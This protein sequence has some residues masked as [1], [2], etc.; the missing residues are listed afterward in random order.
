MPGRAPARARA[1][2]PE[3]GFVYCCFNNNYKITPAIFDVWMRILQRTGDS[4]LW[5]LE[6]NPAAARNLRREAERRGVAP[7]RL[8]FAPRVGPEE[9]LGRHSL[10]GLF[11]DTLPYN[12]HTTASDALWSGVP[13]LTCRGTAFAGRVAASLLQSAG[14]AELVAPTLQE[15]EALAVRLAE[16]AA[17]LQELAARLARNRATCTLFDTD[18]TRRHIEAAYLAMWER[19]R[20]GQPPAAFSV[21]AISRQRQVSG[22]APGPG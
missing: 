19:Q 9:H 3:R 14:L 4:V 13:V 8:V 11:L 1:G 15:Y 18:R 20:N 5:L 7:Q 12:A 17:L 22:G 6:D 21:E 10:A 2:L 16:D